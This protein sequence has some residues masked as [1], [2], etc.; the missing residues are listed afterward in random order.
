MTTIDNDTRTQSTASQEF[1]EHRLVWDWPVRLF[2]WTLV[3]AFVGAFITN[4]LGVSFFKYHLWCGYTVIVL[5]AFRILWGLF[6]TRHARFLNFLRGPFQTWRYARDLWRG[7]A[8]GHAGHNPLGALMVLV[9]L[10]ALGAQAI[11]GLFA[12]DDI[13]NVG[14]LYGYVSK[15][16]SLQFTTLHRKAF[17]WI[18]AAV[19][20]HVIAVLAHVVFRRDNLVQAMI[21]GRK[22]AHT[23]RPQ[24]E[25]ST[26]RGWLAILLAAAVVAAFALVLHYAPVAEAELAGF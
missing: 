5:V 12:N 21:T 9:L 14:P 4:R 1:V 18:A 13:F 23:V 25:I 17:Y 11:L 6:G 24:D 7:R 26:S 22:L 8:H 20:V 15:E 3:G 10:V 16:V 2:H 19:A